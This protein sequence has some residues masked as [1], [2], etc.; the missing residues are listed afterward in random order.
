MKKKIEFQCVFELSEMFTSLDENVPTNFQIL[1]FS[2]DHHRKASRS[3]V[4]ER[5]ASV[6][7]ASTSEATGDTAQQREHQH[8]HPTPANEKH[9]YMSSPTTNDVTGFAFLKMSFKTCPS[10]MC[11]GHKP[12]LTCPNRVVRTECT[13]TDTQT[14]TQTQTHTHRLTSPLQTSIPKSRRR[15]EYNTHTHIHTHVVISQTHW[16]VSRVRLSRWRESLAL[17]CEVPLGRSTM[18]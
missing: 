12:P 10:D 1:F 13:H 5:Q 15:Y 11:A 6:R 3:G 14:Q 7:E 18:W 4:G 2:P 17:L 16:L 9:K 8:A